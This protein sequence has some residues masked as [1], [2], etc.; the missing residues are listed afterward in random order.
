M[1]LLDAL[2]NAGLIDLASDSPRPVPSF[3]DPG[4]E[5][6]AARETAAMV[7]EHGFGL[8]IVEGDDRAK[9]LHNFCS[10][11]INKMQPGDVCEAFFCN[12]KGRILALAVIICEQDRFLVLTDESRVEFLHQHLDRYV[13]AEDVTLTIADDQTGLFLLAVPKSEELLTTAEG[14]SVIPWDGWNV[15][16]RWVVGPTDS[17]VPAAKTCL[18]GGA[19]L[20]GHE[21]AEALRISAGYPRYGVDISDENLAQEANRTQTA[22]SFVKGCYLGQE[23]IARLDA[24]GHVNRQ[25][26]RFC[27]ED[28]DSRPA[29]GSAVVTDTGEDVG[30]ITSACKLPN[31]NGSGIALAMLKVSSKQAETLIAKTD[32]GRTVI[33]K[34]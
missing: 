4:Q 31:D 24:M 8:L 27:C 20:A 13:I 14:V 3:G 21:T 18:D 17:L 32:D 15:P 22:I 7:V 9:F 10:N 2:Q 26:E 1:S 34:Q 12:V 23:P 11:D 29:V 28:S 16:A 33:L 6:E 30:T 5:Y 19:I 25:L